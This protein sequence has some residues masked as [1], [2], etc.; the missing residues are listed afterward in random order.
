MIN[1]STPTTAVIDTSVPA[2]HPPSTA[3]RSKPLTNPWRGNL[4]KPIVT[5]NTLHELHIQLLK[6]KVPARPLMAYHERYCHSIDDPVPPASPKC[7]DSADQIFIDLAT[8]CQ[9]DYLITKDTDLL[10][11]ND[12]AKF[13]I[14]DD[15]QLVEEFPRAC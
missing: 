4:T 14:I 11:L 10:D 7:R 5:P 12:Q 13:Q 9:A 3:P 8:H 2:P 15:F 6:S 1:P